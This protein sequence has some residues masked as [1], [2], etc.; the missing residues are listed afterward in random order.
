MKNNNPL[1]FSLMISGFHLALLGASLKVIKQKLF[2]AWIQLEKLE[3]QV[4]ENWKT[5][6]CLTTSPFF[7]RRQILYFTLQIEK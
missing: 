6:K 2:G 3:N 7:D 4:L 5:I 1:V